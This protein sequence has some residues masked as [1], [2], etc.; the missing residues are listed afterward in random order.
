MDKIGYFFF[1]GKDVCGDE[2]DSLGI[3][4]TTPEIIMSQLLHLVVQFSGDED[5]NPHKCD[6]H[7]QTFNCGP[8]TFAA[9][10]CP[11]TLKTCEFFQ[12]TFMESPS[13][14]PWVTYDGWGPEAV[15]T[16]DEEELAKDSFRPMV[17][18]TL[19]DCEEMERKEREEF[20][21]KIKRKL[22]AAKMYVLGKLR[23]PAE[24]LFAI[25]DRGPTEVEPIYITLHSIEG[26]YPLPMATIEKTG[27]M[28]EERADQFP[29]WEEF[30]GRM[31]LPQKDCL[32]CALIEEAQ[33]GGKLKK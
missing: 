33:P 30:V 26:L 32:R 3:C 6:W 15:A 13:M 24:A 17:E 31:V 22:P 18:T 9:A 19:Q 29:G 10:V 21:T 7:N 20:E 5:V 28:L 2:T 23:T 27:A 25:L 14:N 12:K 16:L 4:D 8:E 11:I 1:N